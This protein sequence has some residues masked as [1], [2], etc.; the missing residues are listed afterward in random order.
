MVGG[1][2]GITLGTQF[3]G[4][5]SPQSVVQLLV[6]QSI[7]NVRLLDAN[8]SML[9]ALANTGIQVMVTVPNTQLLGVGESNSTATNWIKTNV[10]AYL[11]S[12]NITAVC[13]GTEVLSTDPNAALVLVPAMKFLRSALL[14]SNL[15][16]HIK[17]ST[18]H[19][20]SLILDSFPPSQAYFN[21][22]WTAPVVG[23][24]LDFLSSSGSFFMLNVFSYDIYKA[25]AGIINLDYALL[26]PI[27]PGKVVVDSNTLYQYRNLFDAVVDSAFF[28]LAQLNH[29]EIP[30]VVSASGWP[31][32]G[33]P[34]V[35]TDA[36]PDNAAQHNSNLIAH[37]L[38]GTGTPKRPKAAI[39]TYLYELFNEDAKIG[40]VTDRNYGLFNASSM[41]A[42]YVLRLSNSG[43]LLANDTSTQLYCVAKSGADPDALQIA[44]DWAC[45]VGQAN[46]TAIQPGQLCYEPDNVQ[47]HASYAFNNY[48]QMNDRVDGS[49]DF[50]GVATVSTTNPGTRTKTTTPYVSLV[51][52]RPI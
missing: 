40:S 34:S 38:N 30:V 28:A 51:F 7:S 25:S 49:C 44:L 13:V 17:V 16:S 21:K 47:S 12:T 18:T 22:S 37:I 11:P 48:Y 9:Q 29:S 24:M 19:D 1:F 45:G 27:T 46:C 6:R 42:V 39:N 4:T 10:L 32:A 35:D 8:S 36:T 26:N 5:P 50:N 52:L 20:P 15:S 2:V 3:S 41:A 33:D 23:P 31:S 14:S 43:P